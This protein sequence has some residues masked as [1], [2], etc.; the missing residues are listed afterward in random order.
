L[1]RNIIIAAQIIVFALF[2]TTAASAKTTKSDQAPPP[3]AVPVLKVDDSPLTPPWPQSLEGSARAIAGDLLAIG[4]YQLRLYG[5]AAP[6]LSAGDGPASR[7][8]L[9]S[10]LAGQRVKCAVFG[11]TP[12]GDALGQCSAAGA[13]LAEALLS[14]GLAA[15]YREGN[16]NDESQR[17]LAEKY[18][19]AESQARQKGLGIWAAAPQAGMADHRREQFRKGQVL[20]FA[21]FA[22]LILAI[23]TVSITRVSIARTDRKERERM[24]RAR[25]ITLSSSLVA[26]AEI[27]R[28][29]THRILGQIAEHPNERPIPSAASSVLSLPTATFWHANAERLYALPADVTVPLL[30]LHSLHEEATRKLAIA[31]AIPKSAIIATLNELATAT[32]KAI[33]AT[34][35]SLGIKRETPVAPTP[36]PAPATTSAPAPAEKPKEG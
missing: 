25:R 4:D 32:D 12:L 34:E 30:W 33:A 27:I 35:T 23:F 22:L 26:E 21:G 6:A 17:A 24:R 3:P 14:Q 13:D 28:A 36:A 19:A 16:A 18:D 11:K 5:I 15:V 29:A 10:L 7:V 31:S 8:A 20:G 9:D 2:L 1:L